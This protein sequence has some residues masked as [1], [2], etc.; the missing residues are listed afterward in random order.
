[1]V[2]WHAWWFDVLL[3]GLMVLTVFLVMDRLPTQWPLLSASLVLILTGYGMVRPRLS[4]GLDRQAIATDYIGSVVLMVGL[5][6]G[7]YSASVVSQLL[8]VA[9]PVVWSAVR[10]F[11]RGVAANVVMISLVGVA[12]GAQSYGAGTLSRDLAP[13]AGSAALGIAFSLMIGSMVHAALRWGRERADLLEDLQ[14]SQADLAESYRQ[15]VADTQ[16]ASTRESPLS[17]RETQVLWLVSEGCTNR[18]IGN[19]LFISPATVKTHMEHILAKLG[20]TTRTQAVL[21]A[22]T[23]G[24]LTSA[25]GEGAVDARLAPDPESVPRSAQV[26]PQLAG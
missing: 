26:R 6:L 24:L 10:G 23:D 11:R 21:I 22:H 8:A 17:S 7:A 12:V 4:L 1:M 19:R 15:L 16:A 5:A 25:N 14:A 9:C 2:K 3:T 18:E 13:I 20:A